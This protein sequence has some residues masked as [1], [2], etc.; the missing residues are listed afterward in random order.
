MALKPRPVPTMQIDHPLQNRAAVSRYGNGGMGVTRNRRDSIERK[1]HGSAIGREIADR[2]F[3]F[4]G[5]NQA[6]ARVL[7]TY[8]L[9]SQ[10]TCLQFRKSPNTSMGGVV[11]ESPNGL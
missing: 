9:T 7:N 8:R 2:V 11:G 1:H 10:L 5:S 6:I 4:A 3:V